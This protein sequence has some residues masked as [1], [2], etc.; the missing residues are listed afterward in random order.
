MVRFKHIVYHFLYILAKAIAFAKS[1][2]LDIVYIILLSY[3]TILCVLHQQV[4]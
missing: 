3:L 4:P 2:V 1:I